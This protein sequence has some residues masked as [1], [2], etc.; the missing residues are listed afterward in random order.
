M[1]AASGLPVRA[2]G[3]PGIAELAG[4]AVRPIARPNKGADAIVIVQHERY[5]HGVRSLERAAVHR[6]LPG[7]LLPLTGSA[8]DAR[9]CGGL[10]AKTCCPATRGGFGC[11]FFELKALAKRNT[12]HDRGFAAS[13]VLRCQI[14]I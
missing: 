1:L 10:F 6:S 4:H 3:C 7:E 14:Q 11:R 8:Q 13:V 9:E 2:K 12:S 5:L